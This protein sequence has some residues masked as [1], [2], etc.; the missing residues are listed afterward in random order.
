[1]LIS[2]DQFLPSS[3]LASSQAYLEDWLALFSFNPATHHHLPQPGKLIVKLQ[4]AEFW[5]A[6]LFLPK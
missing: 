2:H 5:Y 1:M 4:E 3:V 6:T